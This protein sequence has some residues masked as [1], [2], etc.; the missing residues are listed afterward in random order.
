MTHGSEVS[1]SRCAHNDACPPASVTDASAT[2][3]KAEFLGQL[4]KFLLAQAQRSDT[5]SDGER[6]ELV[7]VSGLIAGSTAKP[8]IDATCC[9]CAKVIH[10]EFPRVVQR[11]LAS[12]A[13]DLRK[14]R[15][16]SAKTEAGHLAELL[17]QT[18]PFGSV[19]GRQEDD[20]A[21]D[22]HDNGC[23]VV[24]YPEHEVLSKAF[25]HAALVATPEV[26]VGV[27][28]TAPDTLYPPH[29]HA[30]LE[31]YVPLG[32][33]EWFQ[34]RKDTWRKL[35]PL[36]VPS[37]ESAACDVEPFRL[38]FHDTNEP[39]GLRTPS[40]SALLNVWIQYGDLSGPTTLEHA[41]P[42]LEPVSD[43]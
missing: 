17:L 3:K 34:Q 27:N 9:C 37:S 21:A 5:Y 39:H 23:W 19:L 15:N 14:A 42:P 4:C 28:L 32:R 30:A 2:C 13:E 1:A 10:R 25:A 38:V 29:S 26:V 40:T 35:L 41:A 24:D 20:N 43:S 8:Q 16:Q 33:A 7:H 22:C 31:I 6:Q 36:F 12:S 18:P 11:H